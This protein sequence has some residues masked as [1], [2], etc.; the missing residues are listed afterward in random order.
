VTHRNNTNQ[1]GFTLIEIMIA[2]AVFSI[3]ILAIVGLQTT[4]IKSNKGSRNITSATFLA[5]ARMEQLRAGGYASLA[6]GSDPSPLNS[7]GGTTGG[8]FTRTWTIANYG[9]NMRRITV[10][11]TWNDQVA[12]NRSISLVTVLSS[13]I[14]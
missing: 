14:D 8:I 1:S 13:Q 12:Q 6:N 9:T 5:E 2:L 4:V 3:A 10:T 7:Q 11:V